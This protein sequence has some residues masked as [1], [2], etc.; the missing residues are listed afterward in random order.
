MHKNLHSAHK[1][2]TRRV[3]AGMAGMAGTAG[4]AEM[5]GMAE[6]AGMVVMR[7]NRPL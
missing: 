2:N 1:N 7:C 5:V 6:M 4:M 3:T